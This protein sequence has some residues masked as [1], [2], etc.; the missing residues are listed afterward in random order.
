MPAKKKETTGAENS[1]KRNDRPHP[2][3]LGPLT[4]FKG[5]LN[6][7]E[8]VII[9]GSFGGKIDSANHSI[10]IEKGAKVEAEICGKN[11]IVLGR[12]SGNILATGKILIGKDSV[13][14]GDL[15]APRIS[16]QEGAKFKG[17]VKMLPASR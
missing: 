1:S 2:S 9:E 15:S 3:R 5:E 8:D 7:Q 17:T 10:H 4:R 13:M 12:V 6:C 11:I 14:T 16:I